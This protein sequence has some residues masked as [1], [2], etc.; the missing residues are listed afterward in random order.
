MHARTCTHMHPPP[1]TPPR[2]HTHTYTVDMHA[3]LCMTDTYIDTNSSWDFSL[4]AVGDK[5]ETR[6]GQTYL[7][8]WLPP[9]PP[10]Q[11]PAHRTFTAGFQLLPASTQPTVPLLLASNSSLPAPSQHRTFTAGFHPLLPAS[12]QPT[13]PLL[14]AS[15]H[16]SLPAPSP[17]YLYCWLP[18]PPCQHPA[19]RT[20]TAGFHPLL[21]ASTQPTAALPPLASACFLSLFL[22]IVSAADRKRRSL[23]D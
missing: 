5:T 11:H 2:T 18:T 23:R 8:C 3:F 17:P 15:T 22:S 6:Q 16:S 10:C 12:T 21:P 9:T 13:V 14:L 1:P 4:Q 19:H 20:F 7:Y